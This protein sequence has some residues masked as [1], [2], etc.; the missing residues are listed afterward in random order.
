MHTDDLEAVLAGGCATPGEARS[1]HPAASRG[2][3]VRVTV[4]GDALIRRVESTDGGITLSP[5]ALAAATLDAHR[6][7]AALLH[8]VVEDA[9]GSAP[10]SVRPLSDMVRGE[11]DRM[12]PAEHTR[13]DRR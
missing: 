3:E 4:G 1:T 5:R 9:A 6:R 7:G 10:D 13:D 8:S 12:L 11:A 2:R